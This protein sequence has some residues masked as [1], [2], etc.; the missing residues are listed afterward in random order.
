VLEGDAGQ[1]VDTKGYVVAGVLE[2]GQVEALAARC[3]GA[4][5]Y[6]IV[7]LVEDFLEAIHLD[8]KRGVDTHVEYVVNLLIQHRER[9]PERGYLAAHHAAAGELVVID[10]NAVSKWRKVSRYRQ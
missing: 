8:I 10:I 4:D 3:T 5:E 7:I 9:Q 6:C 2:A 1:P